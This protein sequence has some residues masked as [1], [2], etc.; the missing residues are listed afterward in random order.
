MYA[1]LPYSLKPGSPQEL[2]ALGRLQ[3]KHLRSCDLSTVNQSPGIRLSA[4][5]H[6][7]PPTQTSS[8]GHDFFKAGFLPELFLSLHS[9]LE[10]NH[11]P[12]LDQWTVR[13]AVI[14]P[15]KRGT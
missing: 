11:S 8:R 4:I 13:E 15:L 12:W 5:Q 6:H 3:V 7:L 9:C 10:Y 2:S 14:D 1:Y